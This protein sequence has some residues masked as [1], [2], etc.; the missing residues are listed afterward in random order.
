VPK[1]VP[2]VNTAATV[3]GLAAAFA[4]MAPAGA[5]VSARQS[6]TSAP[7]TDRLTG[8]AAVSPSAAWAVGTFSNKTLILRWNGKTWQRQT[9]PVPDGNFAAVTAL[10]RTNV[11]AA[12]TSGST[13]HPVIVHWN[14]KSWANQATPSLSGRDSF[15]NGITAISPKSAWAVGRTCAPA[16]LNCQ[17]LIEHWNGKSWTRQSSPTPAGAFLGFSS[18]TATSPTNAWAVGWGYGTHATGDMPLIEHW[19]GQSWTVET[20]P[21]MANVRGQFADLFG[22]SAASATDVWAVGEAG[23]Q[24]KLRT[25]IAHWDGISWTR[26]TSPNGAFQEVDSLGAVTANSPTDVWAVGGYMDDSLGASSNRS[27]VEHWDGISWK[28]VPSP[29]PGGPHP[30]SGLDA[31]APISSSTAWAVGTVSYGVSSKTLV[32]HW[33][34]ESW[35]HWSSPSF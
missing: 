23:S 10:S 18:V 1:I 3:L 34:G 33:N 12:G 30:N 2:L 28:I 25:L 6:P 9:S 17:T 35:K 8:I 32:E 21:G 16:S 26:Q 11:W 13:P 14:G 19:D 15:V 31:F 7:L 22:V 4:V 27:L 20:I 5:A 29:S 24:G